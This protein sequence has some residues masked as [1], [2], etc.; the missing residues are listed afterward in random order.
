MID[1]HGPQYAYGRIRSAALDLIE[2]RRI[3]PQTDRRG[4]RRVVERAVKDYCRR[5]QVG[6]GRALRDPDDMTERVLRSIADYGGAGAFCGAFCGALFVMAA[7][8]W[9]FGCGKRER[10]ALCGRF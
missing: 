7:V 9:C 10:E 1:G 6:L 3:D 8:W 2:E 4:A 5:T